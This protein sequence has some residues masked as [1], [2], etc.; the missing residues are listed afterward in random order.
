MDNEVFRGYMIKI[1]ENLGKSK[2]DIKEAL[3]ESY[4]IFD[5]MSEAEAKQYY[6]NF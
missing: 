4:S 6:Y 2:E 1:L 3:E 5:E